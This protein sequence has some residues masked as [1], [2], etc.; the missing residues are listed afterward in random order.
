MINGSVS[1]LKKLRLFGTLN[2][3]QLLYMELSVKKA[4]VV[5]L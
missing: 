2:H 1:C 5:K 4:P 3:L